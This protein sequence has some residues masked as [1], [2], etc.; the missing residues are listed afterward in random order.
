MDLLLRP[1]P[2][3]DHWLTMM[4]DPALCWI[5]RNRPPLEAPRMFTLMD[6]RS[7]K[8]VLEVPFPH[9]IHSEENEPCACVHLKD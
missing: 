4:T 1:S 9:S 6:L 3:G 8:P 7:S 5:R 2:G